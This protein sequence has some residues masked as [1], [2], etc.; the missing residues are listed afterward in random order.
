M[1]SCVHQLLPT[2]VNFGS[3]VVYNPLGPRA[4]G[5]L[6]CLIVVVNVFVQG[7][8]GA[9]TVSHHHYLLLQRGHGNHARIWHHQCQELRKHQQMAQ[10]YWWG[11]SSHNLTAPLRQHQNRHSSGNGV[12]KGSSLKI[13]YS[14]II[15]WPS[16]PKPVWI[17][18]VRW[19]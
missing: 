2:E 6:Q 15:C 11:Q 3:S 17:F 14:V 7:Y 4:S 12:L 18:I 16:L 13:F 5:L 8:G 10:K 19:S 1:V 9:G